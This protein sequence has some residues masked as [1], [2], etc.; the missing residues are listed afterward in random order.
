MA[1]QKT[2]EM[3]FALNAKMNGGFSGTFSKAQG[4]FSRLGKEIQ[5]LQRVQGNISSY[6]KQD[7][8]V[9]NTNA[10]LENLKQQHAALQ[11]EIK[12]T[13]GSTAA[14][15]R[16]KLKLEQRIKDTESALERQESRLKETGTQLKEAGV[17]TANLV[18]KDAEL[19]QKLRELEERQ[20]QAAESAGTLGNQTANA[21]N[22]IGDAIAAA[23]VAAAVREIMDTFTRCVSTAS[24]FEAAMSGVEAIAQASAQEMRALT[25]RAKELGAT[26]KFTAKESADAMNYMA[27][28]G[29]NASEML[30]G[31]D[32]VLNLAA[33]AGEDL[34]M[35]SDIVT[36]S[37]SAFGLTAADTA[38]F[39]DVLASAAAN[40]NTNVAIMGETFKM[41][42]SIAGALGYSIEDV[43]AA[44]GLMANSGIKGS[45][46]GTALRNMFNG[47]L[48]GATLTAK[49]FGE[50]EYSAVKADGTMK[51]FR[52]TLDELRVL[53]D[54]M[55]GAERVQNAM[56]VAG[57]RGYNGLLAIL[58]ASEESYLSLRDS[59]DNCSG[60]AQRMAK[61]RMD[62]LSGDV[63]LL[64][65]AME[66]LQTTVGEQF[67]PELRTLTQLST[68]AVGGLNSF[69]QTNP[70]LTK[71][72]MTGAGAFLA[73]GTAITG[74]NAALK[75][76]QALN[77]A[78][79][80]T[81]PAGALLGA[82][83]AASAV[84]G[85]VMAVATAASEAKKPLRELT[86]AARDLNDTMNSAESAFQDSA[87]A[88]DDSAS[89]A[90]AY[91]DR[92]EQLGD[93]ASRSNQQQQEYQTTLGLLLRLMPELSGHISQT[94]DQFGRITYAVSSSTSAMREQIE[95]TAKLSKSAAYQEYINQAMDAYNNAVVEQAGNELDLA[96]AKE[97]KNAA[98]SKYNSTIAR[99]NALMDE[100]RRKAAAHQK[101][102]GGLA[103]ATAFLSREYYD[104]QQ[105]LSGC[106]TEL[107][108]ASSQV[109]LYQ[110]ALD[111]GGQAIENARARL[112][113]MQ[114][115]ANQLSGELHAGR[116]AADDYA[117]GIRNALQASIDAT[118]QKAQ[119][120]STELQKAFS[121]QFSL[122]DKA[123]IDSDATVR[124]AQKA[125]DSQLAYWQDYSKNIAALKDLSAGDLN[126]T[127][128]NYNALMNL[129]RTG[130]PEAAGLAQSMVK[131]AEKGKTDTITKLG[132]TLGEIRENQEQATQDIGEWTAGLDD[133]MK[134]LRDELGN[135]IDGLDMSFQ[136]AGKARAT[137][138]SYIH[139]AVGMTPSVTAAFRQIASAGAVGL[140]YAGLAQLTPS[141][142]PNTGSGPVTKGFAAGTPNA[143]PGWAWVGEQ[144][145]ELLRLQGGE[146]ILPNRLSQQVTNVWNAFQQ[147]APPSA[148]EHSAAEDTFFFLEEPKRTSGTNGGAS[149][150]PLRDPAPDPARGWSSPSPD[151]WAAQV[152][153]LWNTFQQAAPDPARGPDA[154]EPWAAQQ[155]LDLIWNKGQSDPAP[156]PPPAPP[157]I[158]LHFH[159]ESGADPDTVS[160]WQDYAAQGG[161]QQA[162]LN[163]LDAIRAD[164]ERRTL[165]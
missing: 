57:M 97:R 129:V 21:F 104:L 110:N 132:D 115:A 156:D 35:V 128:E 109:E 106:S 73:M 58:N 107:Q 7:Q 94:T 70:V 52:E 65:S 84:A 14:L 5:T 131:A 15:E 142:T 12:E 66:A 24:D 149:P 114:A 141:T 64:N 10:K 77:L 102:S 120:L 32:G 148:P 39:A 163:A 150:A 41:S 85:G 72:V 158:E 34:A 140:G 78:A 6:Q 157:K 3:L 91:I 145:P 161:L 20:R 22:L 136:A 16:E 88:A 76:F 53:F 74:V 8:A 154:P 162:V 160:A 13:S 54:Q 33:A 37:L 155:T 111:T 51:S 103:D 59:I 11:R 44:L 98:E 116:S 26:T 47:L 79:L 75:L 159:I 2:Y 144:G 45:V 27:M 87:S 137:V 117:G 83:A 50:Y 55:T 63:T 48:E 113:G 56:E 126:L 93:A 4:E 49:A 68:D 18:Q 125:L 80:F 31:M 95:E 153:N 36:D 123:K 9:Q 112:D 147:T 121:E 127:Q 62:N 61:I 60:A 135:T 100:A 69:I 124:N 86:A 29:W 101:Q 118:I 146:Q 1:S 17:N 138:Q 43:S 92:L 133:Q 40:S 42:A 151:P 25:D 28:A 152:T 96:V 23:G 143:P 19:S 38:H 46:A 105:S 90:L 139:S 108:D 164:R 82:A 165:F 81:G 119:E 122:F 67:N 89:A 130:T 134:Q 71:G 30:S 99:M